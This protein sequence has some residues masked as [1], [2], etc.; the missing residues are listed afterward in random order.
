MPWPV[1]RFILNKFYGFDLHSSARIGLSWIFP[2]KLTMAENTRIFSFSV[3]I[4][5]DTIIIGK[6]ST[7]GRGNWIT[8]FTSKSDSPHFKHQKDRKAEL[9]MGIS[10]DI[11]KN[12]HIDCTNSIRIGN[13]STVAGY[14]S[15]MLTHSIDV[16]ENRQDSAPIYIGDYTFIGTNVVI[17]GGASLPSYSVLG[18]KS[19]LNKSYTEEY[20]LYG[21]VPA[22]ALGKIQ[23]DAKYFHRTTGYVI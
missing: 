7:I 10:S 13:F 1:K 2:E 22:K 3:A 23:Q 19:L 20:A 15:Q 21:G 6:N 17:L 14:Q 8:G 18:A 5:L 11:T 16:I 12:H 9:I 4:H